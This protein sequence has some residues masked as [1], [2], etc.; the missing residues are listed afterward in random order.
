MSKLFFLS[1]MVALFIMFCQSNLDSRE[2]ELENTTPADNPMKE[3]LETKIYS[4]VLEAYA[5]RYGSERLLIIDETL[6]GRVSPDG[7][8]E[9]VM[10]FLEARLAKAP[11]GLI[12]NFLAANVVPRKFLANIDTKL[13]FSM[14]ER[15]NLSRIDD[16][17]HM[18]GKPLDGGLVQFSQIGFDRDHKTALVYI[19]YQ[20][21]S[22]SGWG[23]FT[24]VRL[25]NQKWVPTQTIPAWVS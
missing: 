8:I 21:G 11:P 6:A 4:A 1:G 18:D 12:Q 10:I 19:S 13:S 22:R 17:F 23:Y 2:M 14:F 20:N 7:S 24:V 9:K 3:S 25:E 16:S 15:E 5:S